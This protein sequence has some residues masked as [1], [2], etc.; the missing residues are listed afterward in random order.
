MLSA[1]FIFLALLEKEKWVFH[2]IKSVLPTTAVLR[3]V[4]ETLHFNLEISK[5]VS[6]WSQNLKEGGWFS[7]SELRP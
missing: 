4:L 5:L 1:L 7:G 6:V 2:H 3:V